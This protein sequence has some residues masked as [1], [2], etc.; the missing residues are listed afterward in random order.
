MH[1]FVVNNVSGNWNICNTL[2]F[3]GGEIAAEIMHDGFGLSIM[4]DGRPET[5]LECKKLDE[6]LGG[7]QAYYE[8]MG[9]DASD[10]LQ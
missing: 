1:Q 2:E 9:V 8:N 6:I 10:I 4:G 7:V 5:L 3:L